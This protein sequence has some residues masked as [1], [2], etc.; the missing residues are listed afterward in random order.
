MAD[1][2]KIR[3]PLR[4]I[5]AFCGRCVGVGSGGSW[6]DVTNCPHG[7]DAIPL[8]CRCNFW[9]WRSGHR[10][11]TGQN[12]LMRII[13]LQCLECAGGDAAS[14]AECMFTDCPLHPYRFGK[15]PSMAG[16]RNA[17]SFKPKPATP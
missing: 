9:P 8:N 13:R 10:L 14:V 6:R 7:T 15:N 16:R 5:R 1:P 17:G 11:P 4:A 2:A 12:P 3:T